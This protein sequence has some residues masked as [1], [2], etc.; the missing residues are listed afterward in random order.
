MEC[1]DTGM[2]EYWVL[3][4]WDVGTLEKFIADMGGKVSNNK[5]LPLKITFHHSTIPLFHVRGKNSWPRKTSLIS[6]GCT[7]SDTFNYQPYIF[8]LNTLS[9]LPV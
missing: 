7:N 5:N 2:L 1:W 4:N 3:G 6:C 9:R 8:P